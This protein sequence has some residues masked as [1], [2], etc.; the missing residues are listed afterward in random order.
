VSEAFRFRFGDFLTRVVFVDSLGLDSLG[1]PALA[2]F[3][4][5]VHRLH[6][7][8]TPGAL[9][10]AAGER[11]KAWPAAQRILSKALEAGLGRDGR[12]V[13]VGGGVVCDL[14]AFAASLYMRG[15]RLTLCPT[16]LL[17]MVDAAL[18]GKTAVNLG[19]AKNLVGTFYP[20]EELRLCIPVLATLPPRELLAGLAEALKTAL[21]GDPEL[22]ELLEQRRSEVLGREPAVLEQVVFRCLAVKGRI[23]E[24]D[25]REG[26]LRAILNL[27]HTFGHALESDTGFRRFGH[28]EAVAWG[29]GRALDLGV[30]LGLTGRGLVSRVMKLLRGYGYSLETPRGISAGR[31]LE[32]MRADKKKRRNRLRLVLLRDVGEAEVREA[33][34]EAILAT[35]EA[36]LGDA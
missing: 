25:F 4:R 30:R 32:A 7:A 35:L 36:R 5:N 13:G 19:R 16:S 2:V 20:A 29:L 27:G 14:A 18:G 22:L 24:N 21:L 3:D 9:V 12:I 11:S 28:G 23:V 8:G 15:C 1:G 33:E 17:A 6:G 31:L 34:D 26:G 10:L